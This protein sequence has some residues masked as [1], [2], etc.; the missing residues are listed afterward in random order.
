[1]A[2][3]GQSTAKFNDRLLNLH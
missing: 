2:T 1:M 3:I